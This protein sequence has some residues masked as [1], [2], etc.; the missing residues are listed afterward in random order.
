MP[1]PLNIMLLVGEDVGRH[2]RCYGDLFART[3]NLDSLASDGC[4]F[5][6]AYT[7]CPV[8]APARSSIITGQDP[9]KIGTHLMR[10]RLVD[11]PRLFTH[12]LRDAGYFVN[13][14]NKTDF[15]FDPP[16]DFADATDDWRDALAAG[17]M[18]DGEQPWLAFMNFT[19][20]HESQM[21]PPGSEGGKTMLPEPDIDESYLQNMP[22]LVVPPYLPD[23]PTTRAALARYYQKLE[24]QDREIGLCLDAL[25]KSG[26]A[27]RTAV[28][29]F[30][31]HGRGQIREKRWCYDGGVH[32]PLIV[33]GPG[34]EPGSVRDDLVSWVDLAPTFHALAGI[35][36]PDRYDGRVFLGEHAQP[37]PPCV[38]FGRDRM[39][40]SHDHIRGAVG[41]RYHYI[42]NFRP[43]IPYAQR[44]QY[45]ESSPVTQQIRNLHATGEL[46]FPAD[47]WMQPTK[48]EEELY[49]KAADPHCVHNLAAREDHAN[50][51]RDLRT[52]VDRW[53]ENIDDR[54]RLPEREL[55]D[56]G[57]IRDQIDEY[58]LRLA[59][60]PDGQD[61]ATYHTVYDP[62]KI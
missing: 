40:A 60:L 9:R 47:L 57:L 46:R 41:R 28:L 49:D 18:G 50:I 56:S 29:Y 37:E 35:E 32:L 2:L 1:T 4:L 54:G 62:S 14:T 6:N 22:G 3:P 5:T 30:S 39:D 44:V 23:T 58:N 38:F 10:S 11:P 48:P 21:W 17:R 16:D 12:E 61:D 7:T 52:K 15:N 31:D 19:M 8:C 20:T 51:L 42:H 36:V 25:A 26:Q 34:V 53:V 13:W 55:I 27:D 59:P 45:M 43:D 24:W 33:R